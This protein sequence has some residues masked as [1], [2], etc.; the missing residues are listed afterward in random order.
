MSD[1]GLDSDSDIWTDLWYQDYI[2]DSEG[3]R[4]IFNSIT[5]KDLNKP[6]VI[7]PNYTLLHKLVKEFDLSNKYPELLNCLFRLKHVDPTLVDINKTNPRSGST[8]L[9]FA[10][11]R[12]HLELVHELLFWKANPHARSVNQMYPFFCACNKGQV[13]VAS[14]L[15]HY[16]TKEELGLEQLYTGNTVKT[17]TEEKFREFPNETKYD[18]LLKIIFD[19]ELRHL[20][21]ERT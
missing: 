5:T 7:D 12:G 9:M 20:V 1:A 18:M 19:I 6:T 14:Y 15:S 21:E 4:V 17:E 13:E 8:A 3:V 2:N 11:S 16:V 10:A